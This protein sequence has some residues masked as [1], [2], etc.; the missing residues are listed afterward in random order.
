MAPAKLKRHLTTKHPELSG[1]NEQYFK[2][3]LAF[4]KRQVSMFA[5]KFKLSDKGQEA[6]YAVAEIVAR[7]MKSHTI[8]E[9][10]I[11][12]ACQEIVRIMF[13]EDAV[14]ELNKIPLS[15]NIISRRMSGDIECNIKS[16]ILKHKL[17]ALQVDESTYITGKS[18][19]LVFVRFINDEAIVEDVLCCK[20]LLETRKGQD[21]FDVL[22]SYL[23]YCG[24]NWKNCCLASKIYSQCQHNT[25]IAD[26]MD[27]S[28][29]RIV[30]KYELFL[31]NIASQTA[32]NINGVFHSDVIIQQTVSNWSEQ[33][34][35]ISFKRTRYKLSVLL[36]LGEERLSARVS[37]R[38]PK[39]VAEMKVSSN[40][41][42]GYLQ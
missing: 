37:S 8:A 30:F 24:L 34:V 33:T 7:K 6:S 17:F 32:R 2:R 36:L 18:Q 12:P 9:T 23:E 22:N 4:N 29:I 16:K 31:G 28:E 39:L 13:G 11:L 14:S 25:T 10:V 35:C 26:K 3:E 20:E 42:S 21:V 5:Q 1:K 38:F 40:Q 19:L 15:I 27:K 41:K